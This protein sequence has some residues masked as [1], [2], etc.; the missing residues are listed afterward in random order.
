MATRLNDLNTGH[1]VVIQQRLH[2]ADLSGDLLTRGAY[3]WLCL[4]AEFEPERRCVTSLG[5]TDPRQQPGDLLWPEKVTRRNLEELKISLGSYRYA[6]QYQQRPAPA[7]GGIFK[8]IWWRF[9]RPAHIELRPVEVKTP[10]GGLVTI[11]AVPIP[12][13]FDKQ[14]HSWDLAFKDRPTSD[15]GVVQVWGAIKADRYL[16]DQRRERLDMPA[17]KE[18]VKEMCRKWPKAATILVEDK[19]N[20]PAVIQELRHDVSGLIAVNPEGGKTVRAHAVSAQ[21]ESGNVYLP[22]PDIA[23]WVWDFI[24]EAAAFP[25]CRNDDQVDAMTQALNWLRSRGGSFSVPESKITESP[26]GI[27]AEW[28]R[29]FVMVV[30]RNEIA[31][32]WGAQ[33]PGGT[34]HLYA[35]HRLPHT[36]ASENAR[37]IKAQG[38]WILGMIHFSGLKGS[39]A[40]KQT[41]AQIYRNEGLKVA[42][43]EQG[44]EAG[45]F[46]LQ[47]LLTANKLKVFASLSMFLDEYRIGDDQSPL[48][49]CCQTLV[50]S[51]YRMSTKPAP[52]DFHMQG[53]RANCNFYPLPWRWAASACCARSRM[54]VKKSWFFWPMKRPSATKPLNEASAPEFPVEVGRMMATGGNF[55]LLL[56]R[57]WVGSGMIRLACNVFPLRDSGFVSPCALARFVN[58]TVA[59]VPPGPLSTSVNGSALPALSCQV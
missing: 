44:E 13:Q 25:N 59:P 12:A 2:E 5:W 23:P 8:R 11:P 7:E 35:E 32:L 57:K 6:G 14:I 55:R 52:D 18:A 30:A 36:E 42:V 56:V 45:V 28:P 21:V 4:P 3:E 17:T 38:D 49:L 33:D 16:L 41:I 26:F 34:I 48:L 43:A 40:Q 39:T 50:L 22:H 47:Q 24:E 31:A 53:Q 27:P 51:R 19:A 46:Q 29:A 15:F 10:D 58:V 9:W 20:G 1:K 37:A 54:T